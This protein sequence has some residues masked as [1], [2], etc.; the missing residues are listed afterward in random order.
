MKTNKQENICRFYT[1]HLDVFSIY[2][3]RKIRFACLIYVFL[4]KLLE[5][6]FTIQIEKSLEDLFICLTFTASVRIKEYCSSFSYD[7][8]LENNHS[9][10]KI[11]NI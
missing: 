4:L 6:I 8:S 2:G 11:N 7:S 3:Y 1:Q 5:F 10:W 9:F